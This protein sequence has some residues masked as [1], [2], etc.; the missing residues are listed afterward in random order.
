MNRA[1]AALLAA[2]A[3]VSSSAWAGDLFSN[4]DAVASELKAP[5]ASR[6]RDAVDKLDAWTGDEAK[7][8]LLLAL[9]DAD[10]DVRAH[11]ADSLGRHHVLEAVPRLV[12][13]LGDPDAHLRA[14]AAEA[15]GVLL[16]G[17]GAGEPTKDAVRAVET[18]E[19]ALGDG[20]HEVREAA[21]VA[22]GRLPPTLGK[23][24]AVALTGRL[25]DEAAGVRQRAAE[26]LGRMR[27]ARA[28]VP[29]LSRL[30]DPTREVRAAALDALAAM[31]D[32][33]AVP[34]IVRMLKDP[35][36]DVRAEAVSALGRLQAKGAVGPLVEVLQRGPSDAL[37]ARA[38]FALGQIGT[39]DSVEALVAALDHD[40]LQAAAKEALVRVG[41][42]AV[43]P[44][45]AHLGDA[46][47]DRAG[48]YV[49]LL[50]ELGQA[51]ATP[52]LLDE[53]GRGR[54]PEEN[55]VDA[56]GAMLRA[57]GKHDGKQDDRL[58]VTLVSLLSSPSGTVR[59][60]AAEA[61]RGTAD[62]RATSALAAA[63]N[64]DERDVRV[65]AIGELGRLGA[66]EALG[67]LEHALGS[68]DEA[69]AAAA[70]RALGQ[71][72]DR[73]AVEPLVGALGRNERRVR[74]EAADALAR[75]A[76]GSATP[77]LLRAVRTAAPDRRATAIVA[78]GGV[79][80]HRPDATARELLF[81]YA[82]G[83]D[84]AA[85]LAA[86]D[87]LGAM[88]DRAAVPRL[89]HLVESRFDDDVR[90]RALT[91]LGDIG[92]DAATRTLV[93]MLAGDY[94]DPR[95]RA[96]AAWSLGKFRNS[97]HSAAVAAAL[98]EALHSS[99]PSVR[100]NAAAA[101]YRLGRAPDDL[102][103]LVDDR[104]PAVR[105][106]AALALGRAGK[107]KT[108]LARLAE[109]DEDRWVRAAAKRAATGAGPSPAADWIALD[110]VDFDGAPLGD[111]GYRLVLPDGL[112][113]TGVTDERGV[114]REESVPAGACTL[115]L[116]EAAPSR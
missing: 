11:A 106:N 29:L 81:G 85:A 66:K 22:L 25:D 116:D 70:A 21:V 4:I 19:R 38:A 20:E 27:E 26:V 18:L 96:E 62:A 8:L 98:T 32:A 43:A 5:D 91:A 6:R 40:E 113:R 102:A 53:L 59:R 42:R 33:R 64:D 31:G 51:S 92:G 2:C 108:S 44:L 84:A 15:L 72:G 39:A 10:A 61:L 34:A 97:G 112:Q 111:A 58:M 46:K 79:V 30:A 101:L 28:V 3:L 49:D 23:R 75:V 103:R 9:G 115:L 35:A 78:L 76:D 77:S 65:V 86:L 1:P 93:S 90:G 57:S 71:L 89:A 7:P 100:A 82:E 87:A 107:A 69:T 37:R 47:P 109:R 36:E 68:S 54:L 94:G 48:L 63:T 105:G 45:C 99:S 73:R 24:T 114:I 52:A 41:A 60:H 110:V 74:R 56:L 83:S 104:D 16:G 80:R 95:V 50:R 14:S 17:S 13:A 55:V 67:E 88:G 12:G